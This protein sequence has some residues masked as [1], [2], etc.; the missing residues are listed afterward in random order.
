MTQQNG[1]P[2]TINDLCAGQSF[3][4]IKDDDDITYTVHDDKTVHGEDTHGTTMEPM[5]TY[6]FLGLELHVFD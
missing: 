2:Y 4:I 6:E 5:K 3:R 1:R